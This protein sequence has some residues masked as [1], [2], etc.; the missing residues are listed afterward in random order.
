MADRAALLTTITDPAD[1]YMPK[2]GERLPA[3]NERYPF[4]FRKVPDPAVVGDGSVV[5]GCGPSLSHR[6]NSAAAVWIAPGAGE[7]RVE[8]TPTLYYYSARPTLLT[9]LMLEG[10]PRNGSCVVDV[11]CSPYTGQRPTA[12][13]SLVDLKVVGA[14]KP[15]LVSARRYIDRTLVGWKTSVPADSLLAF[16]LES[17]SA[18]SRVVLVLLLDPVVAPA[19]K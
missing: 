8:N 6:E 3:G 10:F 4:G 19:A 9:G 16:R 1:G 18:F 2:A 5:G 17:S 13:N 14:R 7:I 11:W 15:A 12:A